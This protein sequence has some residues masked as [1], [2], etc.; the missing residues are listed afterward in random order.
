MSESSC[1]SP[2]STNTSE[3]ILLQHTPAGDLWRKDERMEF[4]GEVNGG[5]GDM[6]N[7]KNNNK[8]ISFIQI[9]RARIYK[10][11]VISFDYSSFQYRLTNFPKLLSSC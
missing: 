10:C 6:C 8:K 7:T 11:A 2:Y 3:R 1:A 9:L 4:K 5:K